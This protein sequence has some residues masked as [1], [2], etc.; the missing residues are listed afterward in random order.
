MTCSQCEGIENQFDEE[1]VREEILFYEKDGADKTTMWLI[2]AIKEHGIRDAE[3]LDIGG[4][5]GAIQH[6]L[7][8]QGVTS[9]VHVDGSAAYIAGAEKMAKQRGLENNIEWLHGNYVD[10]D[11]KL[12][13]FDVVT[14]DRVICCYDDMQALVSKSSKKAR[15][16]YGVVYPKDHWYIRIVFGIMNLFQRIRKD[17]FRAFV[18]P[19]QL[20]EDQIKAAGLEKIFFRQTF[21]WQVALFAK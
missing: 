6:E 8:N 4:G 15:K 21:L 18:H 16:Y 3:L 11:A 13:S 19:T 17:P 14:L 1:S 10:L 5:I 7:I 2:E 9:A 20:V 12:K